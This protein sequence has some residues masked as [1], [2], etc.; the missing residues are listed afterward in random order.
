MT[1]GPYPAGAGQTAIMAFADTGGIN[2]GHKA[3]Q[4]ALTM[5]A[6]GIQYGPEFWLK[7]QT[8]AVPGK[9]EGSFHLAHRLK[10]ISAAPA[11]IK[12]KPARWRMVTG[13]FR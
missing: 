7:S 5:C 11:A 3:G 4:R 13:S 10:K 1:Q 9:G 6:S 8:G 2:L 12:A